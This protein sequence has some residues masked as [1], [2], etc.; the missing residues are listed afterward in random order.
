MKT[1]RPLAVALLALAACSSSVA[2]YKPG[3]PLTRAVGSAFAAGT[4]VR[5]RSSGHTAT[6]TASG[7]VTL[8][9][10][11]SG[12]VLL[13]KDGA[14]PTAF[15][16]KDATVYFAITDRF[17]NGDPGNDNSHGRTPDP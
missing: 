15:R 13:E 2:P 6:V 9:P 8:T 16:W 4:V 1:P 17:S 7:S 5:D 14:A 12:V 3:A 11:A 10:D